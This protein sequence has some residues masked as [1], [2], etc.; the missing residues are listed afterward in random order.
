MKVLVTG[1]SG[2]VGSAVV[3]RLTGMDKYQL[4]TTGRSD[5]TGFSDGA[6]HLVTSDLVSDRNWVNAV[7]GVD[8]II[9]SAARVHVRQD[10]VADPL[11][12]FRLVNVKGTMNIARHAVDAGVRRFIHISSIKVNGE[13]TVPGNPYTADDAPAP[14]DSYGISKNEAELGLM[15]LAKE[16]GLEVVNIR[17]VLV[18]GPGVKANFESM[19]YWLLKGVPLP[20]GAIINNRRSFVAIDNLVDLVVTCIDHPAAANQTFLVSDDEDL[21]TTDLM[22]RITIELGKPIRL[23]PVPARILHAGACMLGKR[24]IAQR[25]LGSLQVDIGK[26]KKTLGWEPVVS[27]NTAL[28][29]T[30]EDFLSRCHG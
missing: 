1:A 17:P 25:L 7:R 30:V 13:S 10:S 8:T 23:F 19:M 9:H 20:F 22:R 27:V 24:D 3:A 2:F 18:Y 14:I 4:R 12:E 21:S 15:Q 16:T 29:G 11:A 5:Q 6:E 26:T 28:R